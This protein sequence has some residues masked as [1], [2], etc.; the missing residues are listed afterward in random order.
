MFLK[1]ESLQLR[2]ARMQSITAKVI[3][4]DYPNHCVTDCEHKGVNIEKPILIGKDQAIAE[5]L[6]HSTTE[7]V[8]IESPVREQVRRSKKPERRNA[9]ANPISNPKYM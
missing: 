3:N 2:S 6:S 7:K 8:Q 9:P 1:S 5:V 4:L